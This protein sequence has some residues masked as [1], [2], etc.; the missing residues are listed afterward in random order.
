MSFK[1]FCPKCGD[2]TDI[3]VENICVNCF[4]KKNNLFNVERV[5]VYFC[6][7]CKKLLL[8]NKWTDFSDESIA[9]EVASQVKIV[10]KLDSPKIFVELE[11]KSILDY[12]ANIK[13]EGFL[14]NQLV[15]KSMF[16]NFQLRET[17][18]DSCM[19]LNASYREAILQLRAKTKRDASALLEV[20]QNFLIKEREKDSLSGT[21]K[22]SELKNG[23]DLWIGSKKATSKVSRELSRLYKVRPIVSKKL[24][25]EDDNGERKYR[26]TFCIKID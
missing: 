17:T 11:K 23:Y 3:F 18:C 9:Q 26:H 16:I 5:K 10:P 25:G 13:V 1:K 8:N 22:L 15:E 20:A 7:H 6:K 4:L 2:E 12:S 19:K 21:S 24:I 14:A